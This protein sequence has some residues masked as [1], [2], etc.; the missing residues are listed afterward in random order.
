MK[1]PHSEPNIRHFCF[2][3]VCFSTTDL[4]G[5]AALGYL[6]LQVRQPTDKRD[7]QRKERIYCATSNPV[8][9]VVAKA[10]TSRSVIGIV[11]GLSSRAIESQDDKQNRSKLLRDLGYKK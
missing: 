4:S 3:Q 11:D 2:A 5:P 10:E 1:S 7:K 8:Q 9:V 6:A